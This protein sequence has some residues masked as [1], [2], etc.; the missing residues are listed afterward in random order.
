MLIGAD[1]LTDWLRR[2]CERLPAEAEGSGA[3]AFYA[4]ALT[5]TGLE[6]VV[7]VSSAEADRADDAPILECSP[8]PNRGDCLSVLGVARELALSLDLGALP[9]PTP[10]AV[11]P[12]VEQTPGITVSAPEHC[13]LYSARLIVGVNASA[14]APDWL[15]HRLKQC[16]MESI[17]GIVDVCNFV[18]LELGQPMHAFD[19]D[20]IK[21]RVRVRQSSG[22][23]KMQLLNGR[24]I[25]LEDDCL[26]IA[27]GRRPLAL[28]GIMG[29]EDSAVSQATTNIMLE[30]AVFMPT[31][32]MGRPVRYDL[33]TESSHRFERGVD[34]AMTV[35]AME[36]A[37]A[38]IMEICG[39]APGPVVVRRKSGHLPSPPVI[40]LRLSRLNDLL[41]VNLTGD[42]VEKILTDMQ[43]RLVKT[44]YGFRMQPPSWRPDIQQEVDVAEE[45]MR[46]YGC[47]RIPEKPARV[48]LTTSSVSEGFRLSETLC[49]ALAARDYQEVCTPSFID[50]TLSGALG[51]PEAGL[52]LHNP[53][54]A[55]QAVLRPSI[56]PGLMQALRYN[57]NRQ[58]S[59]VRVFESGP[60]FQPDGESAELA[61]IVY[62]DRHP[63]QWNRK[64]DP[65]GFHDV[66]QDVWA[67]LQLCQ[68]SVD[69]RR[70]THASLHPGRTVSVRLDEREVGWLGELNPQIAADMDLPAPPVLFAL[71]LDALTRRR[72]AVYESYSDLP[73][74]RRDLALIVPKST[75][76]G[77]LLRC[78]RDCCRR[79]CEEEDGAMMLEKVLLFDVFTGPGIGDA[80][81]SMAISLIFQKFSSSIRDAEVD[82][83]M[84]GV[85]A[86]LQEKLSATLRER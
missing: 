16:G 51:L 36:R 86:D 67:L 61:G 17:S 38:L 55:S 23:Q 54:S 34:S 21:G 52:R 32:V 15:R 68:G 10:S 24:E 70:A 42:E 78:V 8:T 65:A 77:D 72:P 30:S 31:A 79:L 75:E 44:R 74:V 84:S 27:S 5:R 43:G 19:Y 35:P 7:V 73:R 62:G 49:D 60:V 12:T 66:K 3:A 56:W 46:L 2:R 85:F 28:A 53:M 57:L 76:A 47:D 50:E 11:S 25:I 41:G 81:K 14:Q 1:W 39:G 80:D 63:V 37:T 59:R 48:P 58:Q 82:R 22:S 40:R 18:M 69:F 45:I 83:W 6:T 64:V 33:H 4:E 29:G 20:R 26:L 71:S 9:P 13:P